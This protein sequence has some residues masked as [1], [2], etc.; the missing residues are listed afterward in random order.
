MI[1]GKMV[2]KY[3]SPATVNRE[4]GVLSRI[5]SIALDNKKVRE[6]PVEKVKYL[7]ITNKI[8]RHM[9]QEEQD[10]LMQIFNHDYSSIK[11]P[12][13]EIE[14]ISRKRRNVDY[15]YIQDISLI[16]LNTG[17]RIGEVLNLTWD[18]VDLVNDTICA[19]N[20]KNGLK[21]I[22]PINKTVKKIL[23]KKYLSKGDDM[24]VFTNPNTKT[25]Y[26]CISRSFRNTAF[27]INL[28][29]SGN[30]NSLGLSLIISLQK[31]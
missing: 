7:K 23:E 21:N 26:K 5:F 6:N 14:K 10:R 31:L 29:L 19:L 1:K 4:L 25:R 17:L 22:V 24:Y 13:N 30:S 27:V 12:N 9:S 28:K 15:E 11:A 18:C 3:I 16:S 20:T 2:I 8:E